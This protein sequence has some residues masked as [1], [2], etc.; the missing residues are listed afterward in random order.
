[1]ADVEISEEQYAADFEK[2]ANTVKSM[3][4]SGDK[5]N[6]LDAALKSPPLGCK[7]QEVKVRLTITLKHVTSI[8]SPTNSPL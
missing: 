7:S 3:L 6:A 4:K 1:M 5:K 8:S 2:K